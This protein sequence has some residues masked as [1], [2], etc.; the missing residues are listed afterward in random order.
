MADTPATFELDTTYL[1]LD[2]D[3]EVA[4]MAVGDDF[5]ATIDQR[6]ELERGR[7]VGLFH[8][9]A[10]WPTWEMHPA[11]DEVVYLL[12]GAVDLVLDEAGTER[13]VALRAR[14]A[15]VVPRG[16][17]HTARVGEAG[18]ALHITAGAGTQVR[19]A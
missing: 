2:E 7:L 17:W 6:S 14:T 5:W 13:V 15:F 8:Y 11:G 18:A 10:D 9:D 16:V 19:P 4:T 1:H 3:A 12:S